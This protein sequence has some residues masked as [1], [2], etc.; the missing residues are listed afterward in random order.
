MITT[1][2]DELF[3]ILESWCN[4]GYDYSKEN[5][6][7]RH[8]R[9]SMNCRMTDLEAAIGCVQLKKLDYYVNKRRE[10]ADI[11]KKV[12]KGYVEFQHEPENTYHPYFFF[13]ILIPGDNDSICAKAEGRGIKLKTWDP[14]H[15]QQHFSNYKADLK[16]SY[17]I[18]NKVVLL[19]VHNR[20][21]FDDTHFIAE[22]I[23]SFLK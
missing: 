16:N 1:D 14:V 5:W 12:L 3:E 23:L 9:L 19:P 7:Y 8:I 11:Y 21:S 22:N 20:L 2:N 17:H 13:G 4:H 6:Q 10:R 18:G 15:T